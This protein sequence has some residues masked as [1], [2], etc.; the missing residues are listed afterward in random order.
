MSSTVAVNQN[1]VSSTTDSIQPDW[2]DFNENDFEQLQMQRAKVLQQNLALQGDQIRRNNAFL[3]ELQSALADVDAQA[4]SDPNQDNGG[5]ANV[6][7]DIARD[8]YE[9]PSVSKNLQAT[10][11]A[12]GVAHGFEEN[13]DGTSTISWGKGGATA[14][15]AWLKDKVSQYSNNTQMDMINL[16]GQLNNYNSQIEMITSSM[17]KFQDTRDKIIQNIH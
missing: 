10:V 16:Q 17:Q 1:T 7:T 9:D 12:S 15:S 6:P 13:P 5:S 2:C 3:S 14:L 4:P 11:D 8:M